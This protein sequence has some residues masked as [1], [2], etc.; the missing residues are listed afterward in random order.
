MWFGAYEMVTNCVLLG[1]AVKVKV[2]LGVSETPVVLVLY[3]EMMAYMVFHLL[4]SRS[5]ES[6]AKL[7]VTT[8]LVDVLE[9]V[10]SGSGLDSVTGQIVF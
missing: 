5:P 1:G 3:S 2:V 10:V 9:M 8:V 4:A 7:A 6:Y